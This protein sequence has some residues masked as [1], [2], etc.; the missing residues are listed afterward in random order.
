MV[1]SVPV[2]PALDVWA[3]GW[4]MDVNIG[5]A[6][7][8]LERMPEVLRV[9]VA[10]LPDEWIDAR[11][12]EGTF[13][14]RDVLGH[15]I[16]GEETDWIPRMEIILRHGESVAFTPFDRFAYRDRYGSLGS[17]ELLDTFAT[18]RSANLERLASFALTPSDFTRAGTHPEFGRVTL[19]QLLATW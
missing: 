17:A 3:E 18:R 11:E 19:A 1:A 8:F 16:H 13:S 7:R 15:L 4:V 12:G 2:L 14:T 6:H 9:L 10:G 5:D